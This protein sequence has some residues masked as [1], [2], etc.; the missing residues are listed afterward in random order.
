MELLTALGY[1]C[2]RSGASLGVFD[3][4]GVS[5]TDFVLIQVKSNCWPGAV[6]MEAMREFPCPPNCRKLIHRWDDRKKSPQVKE[7]S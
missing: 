4:L 1:Y 7:V 5:P 3:V 2:T 6:E